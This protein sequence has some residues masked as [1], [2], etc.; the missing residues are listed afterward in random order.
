MSLA[1]ANSG[2]APGPGTAIVDLDG[3]LC[4]AGHRREFARAEQWDEFHSRCIDDPLFAAEA[5]LVRAW[6]VAGGVV[7]YCTARTETYNDETITWLK[8]HD[9]PRGELFMR[10]VSDK[11]PSAQLKHGVLMSLLARGDRVVFAIDDNDPTVRMYREHG[12][13]CLQ[14]R[15]ESE[16]HCSNGDGESHP[17]AQLIRQA[18]HTYKERRAIYGA[19]EQKFAAVMAALFPDGVQLQSHQDW[20]RFG[21]LTQVISKLC[22]YANDPANGH[23]DSIHDMGVYSFM[24]EAEDRRK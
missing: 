8:C 2:A 15:S 4:D 12:V 6:H 23:V 5:E 18:E 1:V 7:V 16:H 20:V 17:A 3:C 21:L 10:G 22:R 14:P 9:L 19:S 24:L 13:T 11:R